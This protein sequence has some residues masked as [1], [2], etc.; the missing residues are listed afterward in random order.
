MVSDFV[1]VEN[2]VSTRVLK[3]AVD[4]FRA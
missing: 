3:I 1:M 2:A 4:I